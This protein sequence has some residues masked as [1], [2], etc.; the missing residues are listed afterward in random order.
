MRA[1]WREQRLPEKKELQQQ[2]V[3][4]KL[5]TQEEVAAQQERKAAA[6]QRAAEAAAGPKKARTGQIRT[7]T[8]THLGN[9]EELEG[10]FQRK[11]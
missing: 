11:A 5:R 8:N 2:L 3:A 9:A 1:L 10:M 7:W 6:R 4:R